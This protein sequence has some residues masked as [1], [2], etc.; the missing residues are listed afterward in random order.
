MA[1]RQP[2][3]KAHGARS[4]GV[5]QRGAE[6][7]YLAVQINYEDTDAAGVVYYGNYLGYMER[8][9][10]ACLRS[11]GFPLTALKQ[12]HS[13]LFVVTEARLKY[14]APAWLD[15]ELN[16][17]LEILQL[18]RASMVFGQQVRR[19]DKVLVDG[20]IKLAI[21]NCETFK[22]RRMPADLADALEQW[23]FS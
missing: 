8:A 14:L 10:N 17:T 5:K 13:I 2:E 23:S 18:K 12:Q 16:V 3:V 19:N 21:L 6:S 9:R 7:F 22:P 20:E 1:N 11:L 15:D 4:H